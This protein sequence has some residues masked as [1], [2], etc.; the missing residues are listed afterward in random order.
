MEIWKD[1]PGY[2]GYYQVSTEGRVKNLERQVRCCHNSYRTVKEKIRKP[3]RKARGY[4]IAVLSV[5]NKTTVHT[6]HQLVALTFISGF[7]RG[8]QL[9]HIDGNPSNNCLNNLEITTDSLNQFHAVRMG[10]RPKTGISQYRN[11]SYIKN[12]RAVKRW[13]ACIQHNGKSSY[14]WKTFLTEEEAARHVDAILDSIGDTNRLR[15]FP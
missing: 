15:N 14:G 5:D 11:V 10:L 8:M 3:Q 4:I 6:V 1:I 13:A 12:P 7:E 9:N 2:E